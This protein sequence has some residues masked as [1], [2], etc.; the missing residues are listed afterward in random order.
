MCKVDE[1]FVEN[2]GGVRYYQDNNTLTPFDPSNEYD[3][4]K[5]E[6]CEALIAEL[7]HILDKHQIAKINT[8][9]GQEAK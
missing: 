4:I 1:I 7:K 6:I 5:K 3:I 9:F 2:L 8:F